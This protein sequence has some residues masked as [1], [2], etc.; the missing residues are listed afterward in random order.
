MSSSVTVRLSEEETK[1]F[2]TLKNTLGFATGS[3]VVFYVLNKF[4][5]LMIDLKKMNGTLSKVQEIII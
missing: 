4:P 3:K 5:S 2:D 1:T